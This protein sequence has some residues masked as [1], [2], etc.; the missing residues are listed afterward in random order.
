MSNEE[1]I[2]KMFGQHGFTDTVLG[3]LR[4]IG[5]QPKSFG[6]VYEV[7]VNSKELIDISK[8][9][10]QKNL[11]ARHNDAPRFIDFVE[12]AMKEP[13]AHFKIYIV[14]KYRWDERVCV[15]GVYIPVE[16]EDLIRMVKERAKREPD[17]KFLVKIGFMT[18]LWMWWD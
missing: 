8:L 17:E 4:S 15:D 7:M 9:L 16:R 1:A 11:E 14:E 2:E 18:C 12:I 6:G 3:Y 13:L 5:Y 10:P